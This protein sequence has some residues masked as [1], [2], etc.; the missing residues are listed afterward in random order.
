M[1]TEIGGGDVVLDDLKTI[2]ARLASGELT[3]FLDVRDAKL[4]GK[5]LH[6][7]GS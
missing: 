2:V 4:V 7:V 6:T 3:S 1:V 5:A